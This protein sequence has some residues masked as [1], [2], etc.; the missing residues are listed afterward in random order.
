VVGEKLWQLSRQHQVLCITHLPQIAAYADAHFSISKRV[1]DGRT[2]ADA[3]RLEGP[4][5]VEELAVMLGGPQVSDAHR[6][7][8]REI[9]HSACK[10]KGG[11]E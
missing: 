8:A 11:G 2:L 5:L 10:Y 6:E 9:W 4:A 3:V 7:S 1:Q